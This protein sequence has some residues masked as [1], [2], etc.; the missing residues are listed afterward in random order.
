MPAP[1]IA[2][3]EDHL[4]LESEIGGQAAALRRAEGIEAV[5]GSLARLVGAA[6]ET[7]AL[8]TNATRAWQLA[9]YGLPFGPG[10]R[11]LTSRAEYGSNYVAFL[12]MRK[13]TGCRIEVIPDDGTDATDPAALDE[14]ID[15]RVKLVALT[16]V[17]TNG[18]LVNPSAAIG[19][20]ARV[21]GVPYLLDACQAIGQLPADVA[22]LGCDFLYG[23]ARNGLRGPRGT[24]F[25]YV[26]PHM[27]DRLEPAMLDHAGARWLDEE[28][29]EMRGDARRYETY[30][31][32]IGGVVGLGAAVD[33]AL[34]LGI[35]RIARR[36]GALAAYMRAEL[37]RRPASSCAIWAPRDAASSPSPTPA[38]RRAPFATAW[39]RRASK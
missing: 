18:G 2:V 32:A 39:R 10:D 1:V 29:Y 5:H 21:H 34:G 37:A 35:E 27:L 9:F 20:V 17:P 24:G 26:A 23:T 14:M 25:L 8:A 15:P 3:L 31:R 33:Y 6:P 4:R 28:S 11:I 16:W 12:Q 19:E 38:C 30:E 36:V 22:E 13:R 7:I